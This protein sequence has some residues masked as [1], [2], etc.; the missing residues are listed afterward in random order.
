VLLKNG[1][2][3]EFCEMVFGSRQTFSLVAP[4]I[5][6]IRAGFVCLLPGLLLCHLAQRKRSA[7]GPL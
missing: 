2:V 3:L 1:R 4:F 5:Y 7:E 6:P